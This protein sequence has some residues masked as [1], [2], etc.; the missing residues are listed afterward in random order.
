MTDP[1]EIF[2]SYAHEDETLMND[3]RRQLVVEERNGR[4]LEEI[5]YNNTKRFIFNEPFVEWLATGQAT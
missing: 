1:V 3:V 4:I 2:F 5:T